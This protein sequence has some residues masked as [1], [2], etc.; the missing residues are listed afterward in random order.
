MARFSSAD[1]LMNNGFEANRGRLPMPITGNY[2]IVTHYGNY[3]VEGLRGVT[4]DNKGINIMGSAG[5][6]QEA[7][8][9]VKLAVCLDI[10]ARWL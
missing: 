8:M 2:R 4:L 6:M 7:Y 5:V 9:M 1:R 3:N 10:A